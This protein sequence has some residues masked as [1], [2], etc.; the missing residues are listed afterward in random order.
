MSRFQGDVTHRVGAENIIPLRLVDLK[1][2]VNLTGVGE[3]TV[4]LTPIEGNNPARTFTKTSGKVVV[5]SPVTEGVIEIRPV[6]ADFTVKQKYKYKIQIVDST[7]KKLF[8]P[9]GFNYKFDVI[10]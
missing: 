6:A 9:K 8:F 5:R 3:I 7:G 4:T 10:A 1:E 2:S